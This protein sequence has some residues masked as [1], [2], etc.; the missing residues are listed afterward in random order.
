MSLVKKEKS[1]EEL[2]KEKERKYWNEKCKQV[3]I[4]YHLNIGI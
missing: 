3:R 4:T 2:E 1:R